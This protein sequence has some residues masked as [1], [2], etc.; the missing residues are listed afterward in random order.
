M[1]L[2]QIH[3]ARK[4]TVIQ[5]EVFTTTSFLGNPHRVGRIRIG[6]DPQQAVV[7]TGDEEPVRAGLR[8]RQDT[9]HP[10]AVVVTA[11]AFK[12]ACERCAR[13]PLWRKRR[14]IG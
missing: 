4:A 6:T 5:R 2:H 7:V 12:P 3:R 9:A 10:A 11:V 8:R 14:T 1:A 13:V